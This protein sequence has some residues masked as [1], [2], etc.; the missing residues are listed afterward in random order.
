MGSS[1]SPAT[2]PT[3]RR[4]DAER[5]INAILDAAL[6]CF[7]RSPD[8]SMTEVAQTAGVGRVTLYGHFSSREAVLRAL[9]DRA[10][11]EVAALAEVADLDR[12]PADAALERLIRSSW[13]VLDRHRSLHTAA[14]RHLG[15][16]EVRR[17]HEVVMSHAETLIM[18]G[19]QEGVFTAALPH[20]WL[21]TTTYALMHAAAQEVDE[22]R[23]SP[24]DAANLLAAT[25]PAALGA[26]TR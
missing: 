20:S 1:E 6:T 10:F 16:E 21:V 26:P 4:A 13:R 8:A 2:A 11:T 19:Q 17:R 7:G 18:R 25:V 14:V 9:M 22:G 5:N 12:G 24:D 15:P 3:R 23:L